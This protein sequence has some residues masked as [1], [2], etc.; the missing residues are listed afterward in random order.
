MTFAH[1]NHYVP[2]WYQKRFLAPGH[3]E[4]KLHYLDLHPERVEHP[5]GGSHYRAALRRLGPI[6]CFAQD[7]L[8]TLVFGSRATDVIEKRFF[9]DIDSNG[10]TAVAFFSDYKVSDEAG[11][12]YNNLMQYMDAQKLRTPKGL[13][14]LAQA[15]PDWG[16]RDRSAGDAHAAPSAHHDLG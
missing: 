10:A 5:N 16:Q 12:A 15:Q 14:W 6:N 3:T 13:D 1:H 11:D 9:G 8:Y 2:Q 7:D 4:A